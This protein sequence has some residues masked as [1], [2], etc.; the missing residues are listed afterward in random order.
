MLEHDAIAECA[1]VGIPDDTWGEQVAC[2]MRAVGDERPDDAHPQG[3]HPRASGTAEDPQFWL[4]VDEWPLTG[5]GKIQ[6]F[7]LRESYAADSP[8]N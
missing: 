7:K 1:V 2:F 3:V 6:K 8:V 5:S 4:W